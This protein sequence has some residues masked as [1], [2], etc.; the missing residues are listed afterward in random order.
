MAM[1]KWDT[2][3]HRPQDICKELLD[4]RIQINTRH[5]PVVNPYS[6]IIQNWEISQ[7]MLETA[8]VDPKPGNI[9]VKD[10]KTLAAL[11][12]LLKK[13]K[14]ISFDHESNA[15]GSFTHLTCLLQISTPKN[16]Y[17]VDTL[18]LFGKINFYLRE[19]FENPSLLKITHGN[20]QVRALQRDFNIYSTGV[21]DLQDVHYKL[22][23]QMRQPGLAYLA[24]EVLKERLKNAHSNLADWRIRP[25]PEELIEYAA[26]D[27]RTILR[28]WDEIRI[29]ENQKLLH[30]N[31]EI[32]K[33]YTEKVFSF[34]KSLEPINLWNSYMKTLRRDVRN[35]FKTIGQRELFFEISKFILNKARIV[36]TPV[37]RV[38]DVETVGLICRTM[39]GTS[40]QM[41]KILSS[42]S[43]NFGGLVSNEFRSEIVKIIDAHRENMHSAENSQIIIDP[44]KVLRKEKTQILPLTRAEALQLEITP[45]EIE[46]QS[47]SISDSDIELNYDARAIMAD[48]NDWNDPKRIKPVTS[49]Q[50]STNPPQPLL[51]AVPQ[52]NIISKRGHKRRI[53]VKRSG[54]ILKVKRVFNFAL[55]LGLSQDDLQVN[56]P[57][58]PKISMRNTI[59][60]NEVDENKID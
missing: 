22:Y 37:H 39:P 34:P 52:E 59:E 28:C 43:A 47:E 51:K 57:K 19:T 10:N 55:K 42:R 13:E 8:K 12:D 17:V 18:L 30:L 40:L 35:V 16:D 14:V 53:K 1:K 48:L 50:L 32:S 46:N 4:H 44:P 11:A 41:F 38:M 25:L 20:M 54:K 60:R 21:L 6:S 15:C 58:F 31:F 27:S 45:E 56:L 23:N 33:M 7:K 9:Y 5:F 24:I 26:L 3:N 2:V 49:R 29:K 36:D